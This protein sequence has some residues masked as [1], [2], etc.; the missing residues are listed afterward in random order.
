MAGRAARQGRRQGSHSD[1]LTRRQMPSA[2]LGHTGR[3]SLSQ[4]HFL[5]A[6]QPP[7]VGEKCSLSRLLMK[8]FEPG[9]LHQ[10]SRRMPLTLVKEPSGTRSPELSGFHRSLQLPPPQGPQAPQPAAHRKSQLSWAEKLQD[11]DLI[12]REPAVAWPRLP[13]S[14]LLSQALL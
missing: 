11:A 8:L 6:R 14:S 5:P 13:E 3:I 1:D 4:Q 10:S 12:S 7:E 2:L 9:L